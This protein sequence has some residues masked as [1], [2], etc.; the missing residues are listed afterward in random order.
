MRCLFFVSEEIILYHESRQNR[1][2]NIC[3]QC[4]DSYLIV[5]SLLLIKFNYSL[6]DVALF[7]GMRVCVC[8]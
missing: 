7:G 2:I 3:V 5:E 4:L 6:S 1:K 8:V